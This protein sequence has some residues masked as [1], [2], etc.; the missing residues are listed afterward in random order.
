MRRFQVQGRSPR[1]RRAGQRGVVAVEYTFL[2]TFV[3]IPTVVALIAGGVALDR[4]YVES[5]NHLLLATP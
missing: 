2:L 5:R 4:I 3:V 1:P